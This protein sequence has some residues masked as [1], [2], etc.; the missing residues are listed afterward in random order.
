MDQVVR[1]C[2]ENSAS[3]AKTFLTS[4]A[5]VV[6][7]KEPPSLLRRLRMPMQMPMPMSTPTQMPV[8]M[9][10]QMPMPMQMPKK[11]PMPMPN[12]GN[13]CL[14]KQV[15]V[16]KGLSTDDEFDALLFR[17]WTD[18]LVKWQMNV[19]DHTGSKSQNPDS[20]LHS[21]LQLPKGF[22]QES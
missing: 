4:D 18:A 19:D 12:R 8:P 16:N 10:P 7:I 21:P 6:E 22:I 2:L 17:F 14:V 11:K 15:T 5:V 3:V 1:C 9:P 13:F 20:N